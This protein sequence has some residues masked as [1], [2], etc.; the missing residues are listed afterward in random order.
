MDEQVTFNRDED[1]RAG[2]R[3]DKAAMDCLVGQAMTGDR[4]ALSTLCKTIARS[5]LFRVSCKVSNQTDAEDTAQ[6]ILIRVCQNIGTLNDARAFGG[7][8]NSIIMN[9]IRRHM[10]RNTRMAT[11]VSIEEY[12]EAEFDEE[13]TELLPDDYVIREEDRKMVMDIVRG[14][15]ERQLEAVMLH[16]YEGMT[17]TE[18]AEAMNIAKPSVVRHLA[19]AREKIKAEL[20]KRDKDTDGMYSLAFLPM[21]GLL[22]Q[23]FRQ[24]AALM[25]IFSLAPVEQAMDKPEEEPADK[26]VNPIWGI[27][28][29]IA[30]ALLMA[31]TASALFIGN[32]QGQPSSVP[33]TRPDAAESVGTVVFSGGVAGYEHLNPQHADARAGNQ[34][35]VLTELG[36]SIVAEGSSDILYS[37]EET[38]VDAALADLWENGADGEYWIVYAL[39][40]TLGTS[41]SLSRSFIIRH[42]VGQTKTE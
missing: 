12:P 13:D 25:P 9:E 10:A 28:L 14:L 16:Y 36:W 29:S 32:A 38:D 35:G 30:A 7:W 23:V 18:T 39:K 41:Y 17:V 22:T 37:S 3:P 8:L 40:D 6:E 33:N 27:I 20:Q 31:V 42:P 15:P 5:V 4:E 1:N 24:E 11:M 26:P 2:Q 21:G 19:L 34:Y